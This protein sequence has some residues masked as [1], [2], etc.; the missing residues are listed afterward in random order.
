MPP[1]MHDAE[2]AAMVKQLLLKPLA[3][4]VGPLP[5]EDRLVNAFCALSDPADSGRPQAEDGLARARAGATCFSRSWLRCAAHQDNCAKVGWL[6]F[7]A[8][9]EWPSIWETAEVQ[10]RLLAM[11]EEDK[12][13]R[14]WRRVG[15]R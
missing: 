13:R 5:V 10:S 12:A 11:W 6:R 9:Y 4:Q 2:V 8:R 15:R 14:C 1:A 7:L 3:V